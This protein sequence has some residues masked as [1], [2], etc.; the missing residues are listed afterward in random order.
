MADGRDIKCW[1]NHAQECR[2]EERV[3]FDFSE[4]KDT[5]SVYPHVDKPVR[6]W[7]RKTLES[8]EDVKNVLDI[9]CGPS[10]WI[11]LFKGYNYTGFDQSTKMLEL[12]REV[13]PDV[14]FIFGNARRLSEVFGDRKFDLVFTSAVLQHNRHYPD[15]TEI[16]QGIH[17]ILRP[18]GYYLCTEDTCRGDNHPECIGSLNCTRG[19]E[20]SF[21]MQGWGTY[22]EENGFKMLMYQDPSEYL[23]KRIDN[24]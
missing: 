14:E 16:V 9:G 13:S 1:D 4:Y 22:M 7:L 6:R 10:Y 17:H 20:Y 21:K 2:D 3:P 24:E 12:A 23:Y 19:P 18:G 15:K 8:L 11:N 5:G